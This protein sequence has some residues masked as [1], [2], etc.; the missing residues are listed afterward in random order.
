MVWNIT[1]EG[2]M[3]VTFNDD[4]NELKKKVMTK[5]TDFVL[6]KLSG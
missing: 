4:G 5:V 3:Y 2:Q 6:A 1:Q